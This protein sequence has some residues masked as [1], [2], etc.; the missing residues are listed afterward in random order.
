MSDFKSGPKRKIVLRPFKWTTATSTLLAAVLLFTGCEKKKEVPRAARP[1]EVDVVGVVQQD[2]PVYQEWVAQLNG[3]VNAEITPKVQGYLLRQD[4][5]NGYFVKKGQL[6][7]EIDPRPFQAALDQAKA[8]VAAA[9][10][11]LSKA[12]GDVERDTPLA[13]QN[14]IPKKQLDN[15][16]ANQA[17]WKAEVQA[18]RAALRNAELNLEWTK[19]HSP[20]A[21]IAGASNAQVGDLVG[22]STKMTIVS[23]INPILAYF[24]VSESAFLGVAPRITQIISEGGSLKDV[25]LPPISFIQANDVVYP[26]KGRFFYVNRQVGTQ[27]GTIQ[28]AA[29][30]PNT[31]ATLRPGGFGRVRVQTGMNKNALLVPQAAVIE[32]Q[33]VYQVVVVTPHNKAAFRP[34]KVGERTGTDW[35]IAEGLKPHERVVVQG[36]MN[37]K[38]GMPVNPKPAVATAAGQ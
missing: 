23:Q 35:V 29:E 9:E 4:Y 28:M 1:S 33:S 38:E 16:I 37:L 20:I 8:E 12:Q 24:N 19:V 36:F 13:A 10:A 14:A 22:T 15:D 2:V 21:G 26:H 27:T 5:R 31:D 32:T 30:F 7:F 34:V 6:L 25:V 17:S 11:N 3:F 18:R